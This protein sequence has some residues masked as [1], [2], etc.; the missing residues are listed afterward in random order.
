[1]YC[2]RSRGAVTNLGGQVGYYEFFEKNLDGDAQFHQLWPEYI[3][4]LDRFGHFL[5]VFTPEPA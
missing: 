5:Q 4:G 2:P 1:M 3:C